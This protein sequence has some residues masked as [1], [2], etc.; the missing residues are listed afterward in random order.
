[1]RLHPSSALASSSRVLV[2]WDEPG[3]SGFP[4]PGQ[5]VPGRHRGSVSAPPFH[6]T[7]HL[8]VLMS[9]EHL[10]FERRQ[11]LH[12]KQKSWRSSH[13]M[14]PRMFLALEP[15]SRWLSSGPGDMYRDQ[16]V[17]DLMLV[18]DDR[19]TSRRFPLNPA[20]QAVSTSLKTTSVAECFPVAYWHGRS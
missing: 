12:G 18:A 2:A 16:P 3:S 14:D 8:V 9:A 5:G 7:G 10:I 17:F 13:A 11:V 1:M 4:R 6:D 19:C 15:T 20:L